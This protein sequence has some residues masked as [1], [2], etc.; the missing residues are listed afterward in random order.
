VAEKEMYKEE[1]SKLAKQLSV[2]TMSKDTLNQSYIALT[3]K[4]E[5][6]IE[7]YRDL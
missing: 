2:E 7:E 5:R 6:L 3:E 4:H 1:I